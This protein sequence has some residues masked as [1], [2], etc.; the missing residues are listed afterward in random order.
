[1]ILPL[2]STKVLYLMISCF[3]VGLANA[4]GL[5]GGGSVS[6]PLL[7]VFFGYE[8]KYAIGLG[9]VFVFW[10][11]M[12][13]FIQNCNKYNPMETDSHLVS[14]RTVIMTLPGAIYGAILGYF[15]N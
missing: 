14:Y 4:A 8:T 6:V 12:G 1:M 9:Y 2:D 13:N 5:G 7:I 15:I 3:I 10:G 11:G